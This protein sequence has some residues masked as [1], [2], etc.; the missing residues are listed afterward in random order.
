MWINQKY[1]NKIP[2]LKTQFA[3]NKPFPHLIL[4]D[5]FSSKIEAVAAALLKEKFHE[6]NADLYQ[7]QQT[8]DCKKATQSAVKAFHKFFSSKEFIQLIS[9]I[10]NT[11]LKWIDMS[12]FIYGDTDY[13]LPHDDRL[14]GRKIAYILNLSK[15]FTKT[16]G[17]ALQFFKGSKI[18]KSI[19][20]AFN[21]FTIFKVS[22]KSMH[23]VQEIMSDKKRLSFAGWFHG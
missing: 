10:T 2:Q 23:Q 5:F 15:G 9:K 8:G 19:P 16:D 18:V 6:L 11:K 12:G 1:L 22:P 4:H 7:F 20:P 21:T 3:L 13:L 14:S 17:G